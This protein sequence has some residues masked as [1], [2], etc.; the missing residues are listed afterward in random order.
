MLFQAGT[1]P[2]QA[3]ET[4]TPDSNA[5]G[6]KTWVIPSGKQ[7]RV[8]SPPDR[9]ATEKEAVELVKPASSRDQATLEMSLTEQIIGIVE[10][11]RARDLPDGEVDQMLYAIACIRI[12]HRLD[13]R[14]VFLR[15]SGWPTAFRDLRSERI[16]RSV[17]ARW[18][19]RASPL[20]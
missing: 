20:L 2:A 13:T 5:G 10:R 15:R 3:R 8:P 6:W 1:P 16:S 9:A 12:I 14:I 17:M 11:S 19:L 18:R 7:Y 4:A